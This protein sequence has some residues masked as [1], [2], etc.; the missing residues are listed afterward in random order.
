[1]EVIGTQELKQAMK[2]IG[3]FLQLLVAVKVQQSRGMK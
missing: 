3:V 2:A 1:M